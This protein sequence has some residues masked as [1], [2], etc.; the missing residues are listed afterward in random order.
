[1][2]NKSSRSSKQKR[3]RLSSPPP[4]LRVSG[5]IRKSTLENSHRK[6]VPFT[7]LSQSDAKRAGDFRFQSLDL[8]NRLV[9]ARV[10]AGFATSQL[11]CCRRFHLPVLPF[12]LM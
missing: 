3:D 8:Q 12:S 9:G 1:M 11:C 7:S 10:T 5:L 2:K 4:T 6:E